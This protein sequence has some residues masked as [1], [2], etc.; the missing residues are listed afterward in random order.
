MKP[1]LEIIYKIFKGNHDYLKDHDEQY[2]PLSMNSQN[3]KTALL[4]C[5]DSRMRSRIFGIDTL[6][7]IFVPG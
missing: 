6:N 7:E 5:S 1:S 3:P 2:C 4:I